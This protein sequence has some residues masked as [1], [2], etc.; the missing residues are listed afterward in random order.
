MPGGTVDCHTSAQLQDHIPDAACHQMCRC[1]TA[2]AAPS[3]I[4]AVP[5]SG[6]HDRVALL[7]SCLCRAGC[8]VRL[9]GQ[10][11]HLRGSEGTTHNLRYRGSALVGGGNGARHELYRQRGGTRHVVVVEVRFSGARVQREVEGPVRMGV[12]GILSASKLMYVLYDGQT[13]D[14]GSCMA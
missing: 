3:M 10:A 11:R 9:D 13:V 7:T 8:S 4:G 5:L 12:C 6:A 14:T 1:T 2:W